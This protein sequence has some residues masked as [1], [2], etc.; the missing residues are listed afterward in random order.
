MFKQYHEDLENIQVNTEK[1]RSYYIPYG[2]E[3]KEQALRGQDSSRHQIS[4][5]LWQFWFYQN[6]YELPENF[7]KEPPENLDM[8]EVSSCWQMKVMTIIS[9]PMLGI[10]SLM[11]SPMYLMIILLV[12]IS[13]ALMSTR[14]MMKP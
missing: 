3:E 6:I 9:I 8:I 5:G 2:S 12:F 4:N 10:Q 7:Y 14:R 1:S 11:M 13:A